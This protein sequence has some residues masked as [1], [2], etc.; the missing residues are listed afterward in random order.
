MRHKITSTNTNNA[1]KMTLKEFWQNL[2]DTKSRNEILSELADV[3]MKSIDTIRA[4]MLAYRVPDGLVAKAINEHL[5]K[6][7]NVKIKD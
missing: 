3:T 6:K 4:Y 5:L 2:P 7:Y 1:D